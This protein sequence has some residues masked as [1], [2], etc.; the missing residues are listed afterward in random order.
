MH[1]S[2]TLCRDIWGCVTHIFYSSDKNI[3]LQN[4][5]FFRYPRLCKQQFSKRL[6][7]K[8]QRKQKIADILK[9]H[10]CRE[11]IFSL[12]IDANLFIK[13]SAPAVNTTGFI[14]IRPHVMQIS[15]LKPQFYGLLLINYI[16]DP[17]K[18]CDVT[19]SRDIERV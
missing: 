8:I 13:Y 2:F 19:D 7:T 5:L 14:M 18:D 9:G 4:D 3:L 15:L 16:F 1:K 10:C 17:N 6:W 12:T 11:S